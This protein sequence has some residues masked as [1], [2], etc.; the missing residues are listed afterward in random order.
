[1]TLHLHAFDTPNARKISV[2]LEEMGL[3][4]EVHVVDITQGEQ[5][6]PAFLAISPNNKIPALVDTDGPAGAPIS[7]FESGLLYLAE[8]PGQFLPKDPVARVAVQRGFAV[9][10]RRG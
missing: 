10:L 8:K 3:P 7:V 5:F 2:A 1:M 4:Y 9:P 6:D